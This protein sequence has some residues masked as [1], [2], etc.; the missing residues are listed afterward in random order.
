MGT[1]RS[2]LAGLV[3]AGTAL[4]MSAASASAAVVGITGVTL[5]PTPSGNIRDTT[6]VTSFTT[7]SGTWSDIVGADSASNVTTDPSPGNESGIRNFWGADSSEIDGTA[8]ITGANALDLGHGILSIST[9]DVQFGT[10][11]QGAGGSGN[12]IFIF[13]VRG[14]EQLTIK[15]LDDSGSPI[16]DFSL[17]ISDTDWG[18]TGSDRTV[19]TENVGNGV[20]GP[21]SHDVAGV[22]FDLS[23]FTGTGELAGVTGLRITDSAGSFGTSVVGYTVPEPASAT[24]LVVGGLVLLMPRRRSRGHA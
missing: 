11:L 3:L 1:F 15:P 4:A 13:E 9:I 20:I 16:G 19:N 22:A 7:P 2:I 5:D 23:D 17:S 14:D 8:S 18:D 12:D 6:H 10:V 24:L 21:Y